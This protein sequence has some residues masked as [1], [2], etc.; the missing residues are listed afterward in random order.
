MSKLWFTSDT[1]FGDRKIP[2]YCK[3][4]FC[5]N[6]QE[7]KKINSI[8]SKGG[9]LCNEWHNWTS[10]IDSIEKM[11]EHLLSKIN[12]FV[13]KDDELWH[14]GD[15]CYSQKDL[16][17]KNIKKYLDKIN[18]KNIYLIFGNHD[19][20]II[21]KFFKESFEIKEITY[22]NKKIT[23]NH[24]AHAIWNESHKGSWMLY[25]HSHSTAE[26]WLDR[27]IPERFSMDVGVDNIYKLFGEYRPISFEEINKIFSFKKGLSI[28]N[29]EKK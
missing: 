7:L 29:S 13:M 19:N 23:L 12:N 6:K 28:D 1:H 17:E 4:H 2:L 8:S 9:S 24:Y 11:N 16:L 15:F 10:S 21:G 3:R 25:G 27:I 22:K 5:L 18:C 20:K 26:Q 14:L